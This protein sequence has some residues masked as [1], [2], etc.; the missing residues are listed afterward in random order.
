MRQGLL[1]V[2]PQAVGPAISINERSSA[3]RTAP[4]PGTIIT[5]PE[6]DDP[7]WVPS[8]TWRDLPYDWSILIENGESPYD[9]SVLIENGELPYDWSVLIENGELPYNWTVISP[10]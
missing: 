8:D 7:T 9:W 5:V 3:A 4:D 10:P 2:W 6:L 1:F